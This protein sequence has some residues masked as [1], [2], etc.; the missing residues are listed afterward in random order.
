M[1][2]WES[3][4]SHSSLAEHDEEPVGVILLGMAAMW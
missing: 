3:V 1:S 2:R 4:A